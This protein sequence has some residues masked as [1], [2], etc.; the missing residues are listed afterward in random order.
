MSTYSSFQR[1]TNEN[2]NGLVRRWYKKR[3]D[4]SLVSKDKIKTLERKVNNIP[5]KMFSY[6]TAY[7][8]YQENI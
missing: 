8:I 6:K 4:F 3:T 1:G 5:R 7:Q 2:I